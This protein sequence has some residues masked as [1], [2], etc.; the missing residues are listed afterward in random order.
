[1]TAR[2][3][4]GTPA[5]VTFTARAERV[6]VELPVVRR[7]WPPNA[8]IL[9]DDTSDPAIRRWAGSMRQLPR[10]ELS[11][12]HRMDPAQ[13]GDP[14]PWLRAVVIQ[15]RRAEAAARRVRLRHAGPAQQPE[16][17]ADGFTEVYTLADLRPGELK[18]ARWVVMM[19]AEGG[20]I[21]DT[22]APP[23]LLD[24]EFAG[25]R[26]DTRLADRLWDLPSDLT[27]VPPAVLAGLVDTGA[28]L[29]QSGDGT[30]GGR[31]LSWFGVL[32]VGA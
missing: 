22:G 5:A 17:G 29:P 30:A 26:I 20:N 1:V 9:L 13:L 14:D 16:L 3:A 7:I 23:Q 4:S 28:T 21:V 24:A 18:D 15:S 10:L 6:A 19:R 2:I 25:A 27:G 8:V 32:G 31:F 11:F 12:N